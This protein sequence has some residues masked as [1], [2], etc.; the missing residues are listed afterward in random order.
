MVFLH[1]L[2]L[3]PTGSDPFNANLDT[4][5][6]IQ[7]QAKEQFRPLDL[8][9]LRKERQQGIERTTMPKECKRKNDLALSADVRSLGQRT[10][11]VIC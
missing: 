9:I 3:S 1:P 6:S 5:T 4:I 8:E 7:R 2:V 11:V 10:G